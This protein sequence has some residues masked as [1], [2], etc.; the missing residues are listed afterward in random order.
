MAVPALECRDVAAGHPG[1]GGTTV[2]VLSGLTFQVA[3]SGRL[4]VLGRSGSGK[5]TLLRLLNRLE[6]PLEGT[7]LFQGRPL[8]GYDP[9]ALRR[10]VAL[11]LQTPVMFE[12]T[13]RD[14]LRTRPRA[15]P[16]PEDAWLAATLDDV[17]LSTDFLAR[18]AEALS[19]GEKQRVCLA[20]ALVPRPEVLLLDE[21]TSALDPRSL[22][23][24]ADLILTLA[25][26]RDLA[27]VTATHQPDL[28]R[29]LGGEV[30][31]LEGGTGRTHPSD[32]DVTA[33][34]GGA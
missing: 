23:V 5:S 3:T 4:V 21:P 2:R 8:R 13:V 10:K 17:G 24:I 31:L 9:L 33:F 32:A 6:E 20:R 25:A 29:R 30:L 12:G 27:I 18:S 22:G 11:V 28:V 34:L 26:R 19:V 7:I 16:A 1:P 15:A 14:N